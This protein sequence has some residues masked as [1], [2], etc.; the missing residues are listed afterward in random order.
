MESI[1]NSIMFQNIN[2][3]K[4]IMFHN[5]YLDSSTSKYIKINNEIIQNL[6]DKDEVIFCYYLMKYQNKMEMNDL[7]DQ[8][9]FTNFF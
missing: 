7:S 1:L 4:L 2:K 8:L 9:Q 3:Q 6:I 5:K